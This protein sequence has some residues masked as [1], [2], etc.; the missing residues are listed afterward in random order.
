MTQKIRDD[1]DRIAL[2]DQEGWDHNNHYHYF[3][4]K[5]LPKKTKNILDIGCGTGEF[6]RLLAK[7]ADRVVAIDLSPNMI[8]IARQRSQKY[9]NI[10]FQVADILQWELPVEQFDAIV[11]IATVHHLPLENLLPSIKAALNPGGKLVILDLLEYENIQDSL[12]DVVAVPLNWLLQMLKNRHIK[13]TPE[14]AAAM[15]EHLHTDKYLTLSQVKQIYPNFLGKVKMR[16]HLF[17]RYS[18]I[19][20]KD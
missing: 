9:T 10:D 16:K 2:Y 15:Q 13:S 8:E 20:Q 6:S 7:S 12:S 5:Q 1:F 14:M 17:W 11:S 3:L 19:W 4:L 18:V